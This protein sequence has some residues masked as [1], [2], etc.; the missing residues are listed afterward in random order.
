MQG[1][2]TRGRLQR[3]AEHPHAA[4]TQS[5]SNYADQ[6]PGKYGQASTM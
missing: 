6:Y 1:E 5:D 3:G 4:W 2:T